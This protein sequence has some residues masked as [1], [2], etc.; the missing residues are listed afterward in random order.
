MSVSLSKF[1][2]NTEVHWCHQISTLGLKCLVSQYTPLI[3]PRLNHIY[4]LQIRC[5]NCFKSTIPIS[6]DDWIYRILKRNDQLNVKV[7]CSSKTTSQSKKIHKYVLYHFNHISSEA[8]WYILNRKLS[9]L[10]DLQKKN[11][12]I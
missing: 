12:I 5:Q 7:H 2:Y 1:Y 3:F 11:K 6:E 10:E 4:T 9:D 8:A